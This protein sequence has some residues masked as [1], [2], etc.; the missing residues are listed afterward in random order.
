M[1]ET[2]NPA[3]VLTAPGTRE[4]ASLAR[5]RERRGPFLAVWLPSFPP[6]VAVSLCLVSLNW[7]ITRS[8]DGGA[9]LGIVSASANIVALVTVAAT[10]GVVD[11][12]SRRRAASITLLALAMTVVVLRL[13]LGAQAIGLRTVAAAACYFMLE[14]LYALYMATM[15]TTNA[16]LAP[17]AW[18]SQRTATLIQM[19]PQVERLTAPTVASMLIAAGALT[20]IPVVALSAVILVL[21]CVFLARKYFDAVTGAHGAAAGTTDAA[22]KARPWVRSLRDVQ[23][24]LRIIRS[25]ADLKFL[26]ILGFLGNVVVYPFYT[27]LP[28]YILEYGLT[29]HRQAILYGMAGS[30]YGVGLLLG[31]SVMV[32]YRRHMRGGHS[33]GYAA[34]SMMAICVALLA[35]SVVER[36]I[37]LIVAMPTVGALFVVLIATAGA[38]WLDVTSPEARVRVFSLRRLVAFSGIPL[39]MTL[40]GLGGVALGYFS[41]LR[42]LLLT[43]LCALAVTWVIRQRL[44]RTHGT[45]ARETRME[46]V[47]G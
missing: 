16:D 46:K 40:T 31:T 25:D 30:G 10:S 29:A 6:F 7:W 42:I 26:L 12:T 19:Q 8:P 45:R 33:L 27:L 32:L 20:V 34:L 28:S 17:P 44:A 38:V 41:F 14:T 4:K 3:R 35:V 36:P 43:V 39:G 1:S 18:P 2:V 23:A 22:G 47:E 9:R 21:V 5:L 24:S 15:E 13:L 37:V 11:R